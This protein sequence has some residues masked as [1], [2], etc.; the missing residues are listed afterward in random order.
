MNSDF[1]L[2]FVFFT[3]AW[4]SSASGMIFFTSCREL[5]AKRFTSCAT[6][7]KARPASPACA[8]TI[9]AFNA[10]RSMLSATSEIASTM[11]F[12]P[13]KMREM[14]KIS[15]IKYWISSDWR[16]DMTASDS[17]FSAMPL[18]ERSISRNCA[19]STSASRS[20]SSPSAAN[21]R[22]ASSI[23]R[24]DSSTRRVYSSICAFF[25]RNF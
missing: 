1:A 10:S 9:E 8:A 5:S 6:T 7:A 22:C 25:S 14:D 11:S 23:L 17:A 4:I 20:F 19:D 16:F 15:L 18:F 3:L 13:T 24:F 2:P 12:R 21:R